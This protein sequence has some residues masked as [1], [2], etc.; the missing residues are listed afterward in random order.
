MNFVE[1]KPERYGG[2]YEFWQKNC[3]LWRE[4]QQFPKQKL[5]VNDFSK[6]GGIY[7]DEEF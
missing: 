3:E 5:T 1:E 6:F 4:Y 2:W 7:Q